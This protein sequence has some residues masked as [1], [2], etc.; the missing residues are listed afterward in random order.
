MTE[1]TTGQQ[2]RAELN[3]TIAER[4]ARINNRDDVA[5]IEALCEF[6]VTVNRI[7][8]EAGEELV[9]DDGVTERENAGADDAD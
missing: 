3:A 9:P 7:L 2:I 6:R 8:Y 1:R 5:E 4:Q